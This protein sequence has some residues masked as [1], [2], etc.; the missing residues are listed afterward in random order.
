MPDDVAAGSNVCIVC[1]ASTTDPPVA[2]ACC[3]TARAAAQ[4]LLCIVITKCDVCGE[5]EVEP[6]SSALTLW[7]TEHAQCIGP[8][9]VS[10][11]TN[12]GIAHALD[13]V[14]A[15]AVG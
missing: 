8:L 2:V 15:A 13:T 5:E 1:V 10:S 9:L 14:L 11:L 4:C 3:E 7:A 12:T 6:L